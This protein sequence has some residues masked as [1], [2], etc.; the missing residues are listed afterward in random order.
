V[1]VVMSKKDDVI[2]FLLS[3]CVIRHIIL[4]IY[5]VVMLGIPIGMSKW[6]HVASVSGVHQPR[7]HL[8]PHQGWPKFVIA[9]PQLGCTFKALIYACKPLKATALRCN[10]PEQTQKY[11]EDLHVVAGLR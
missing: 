7:L 6:A 3:V 2:E 11:F 9:Q 1:E 8:Q 10:M 5:S 4:V